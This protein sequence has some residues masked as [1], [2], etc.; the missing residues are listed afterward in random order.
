MR[1]PIA[2][3]T[4]NDVV[5]K[6][7]QGYQRDKIASDMQLGTGT[8]SEIITD[9][10]K[11]IGLPDAAALRQ[12]A[13]ELRRIG[14]N[15]SECALGCRLMNLIAKLG[16]DEESFESFASKV[17]SQCLER[18]I[19]PK[20]IV[21]TSEQLL[22]LRQPLQISQLPEYIKRQIAEVERLEN[23]LK[24]LRDAK[25]NAQSETN[26][27][28][29]NNKITTYAVNEYIRM[30]SLLQEYG[31]TLDELEIHKLAKVLQELKH[32]EFDPMTIANKLYS[33]EHLQKRENELRNSITLVEES[34][35][36]ITKECSKHEQL[37]ASHK[38]GLQ[39]YSELEQNGIRLKELSSLR[40]LVV[41]ISG[42]NNNLP[43]Y[44]AFTKFIKDIESQ[45]DKKLGFER[46]LTD[47]DNQLRKSKQEL[48]DLSL[49][50]AQKKNVLDILTELIKYGVTEES[51][52]H[53]TQIIKETKL[54][55][56]AL[57]NDLREYGDIKSAYNSL[58]T[59]VL[60][61]KSEE[62]GLS[63]RIDHDQKM[64]DVISGIMQ[65]GLQ[66]F[67][68][69][70]Q[71]M[72]HTAGDGLNHAITSYVEKTQ[73]AGQ[74]LVHAAEETKGIV[75]SL[76]VEHAKQF[77]LF[78]KIGSYAEFG[79]LIKAARGQYVDSD[80]LRYPVIRA[81]DIMNSRLNSTANSVTKNILE[82]ARKRLQSECL[83]PSL[84]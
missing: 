53:L 28:L 48:H 1:G 44:Y 34:L 54:D 82:Q 72:S 71:T 19:T 68:K 30:R 4:K 73:K 9:W 39:L 69:T 20:E 43:P 46:K 57:G 22:S 14:I 50:Y 23:E 52:I 80:E 6:W 17:Y 38:I 5:Q 61:L 25:D 21:E 29:K 15:T 7:L 65:E 16:I 41:E 83:I 31:L 78:H 11:E 49:D 42:C 3:D 75:Q 84:S 45:Y 63:Q 77:D 51:I 47:M 10:K 66:Q 37:L 35:N 60:S 55:V 81:I 2:E 70:I 24:G 58:F 79:P 62:E 56:S 40:N 8:V 32:Y 18:N 26:K 64:I 74:Q 67:T 12:F 36:N 59:K 33:I 27:T 13:T 76:N